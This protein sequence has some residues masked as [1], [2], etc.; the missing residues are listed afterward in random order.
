ML[1]F[2]L[3]GAA[4]AGEAPYRS[5]SDP[6]FGFAIKFKSSWHVESGK[7]PDSKVRVTPGVP[8]VA[9]FVKVIK[10]ERFPNATSESAAKTMYSETRKW[11][12]MMQKMVPGFHL[13][14]S[15]RTRINQ[16]SYW[17]TSAQFDTPVF[18]IT[19]NV[20]IRTV[21]RGNLYNL[22][23]VAPLALFDTYNTAFDDIIGSF[24]LSPSN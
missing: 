4:S 6:T 1:T 20:E 15:S 12:A 10:S 14:E 7:L 17:K 23:C 16:V 8:G 2:V 9:C 3:V 21:S 19:R 18:E 24:R 5:Y 11:E 13:I 22:A